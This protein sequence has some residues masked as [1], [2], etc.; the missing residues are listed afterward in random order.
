ME[1]SV[2]Y[3]YPYQ[4]QLDPPYPPPALASIPTVTMIASNTTI[5]TNSSASNILVLDAS[6]SVFS[7]LRITRSPPFS[8]SSSSSYVPASVLKQVVD[9]SLSSSILSMSYAWSDSNALTQM[10]SYTYS[11]IPY[12]MGTA[13]PTGTNITV[14]TPAYGLPTPVTNV[15]KS[16]VTNNGFTA[17]WSGG[18]GLSVTTVF[19]INGLSVTPSSLSEG[20]ATFTSL[21]GATWVLVI[22]PMNSS[23]NGVSGTVT[24]TLLVPAVLNYSFTSSNLGNGTDSWRGVTWNMVTVKNQVTGVYSAEIYTSGLTNNTTSSPAIVQ[25]FSAL[26]INTVTGSRGLVLGNVGGNKVYMT[27]SLATALSSATEGYDLGTSGAV[28][29]PGV[30]GLDKID[31]TVKST[32]F[33]MC[34]W[35]F[36]SL[37]SDGSIMYYNVDGGNARCEIF[38][39]NGN[40]YVTTYNAVNRVWG[41][42]L[43]SITGVEGSIGNPVISSAG[44]VHIAIT[45]TNNGS[46]NNGTLKMYYNGTLNST[47]NNVIYPGTSANGYI[48]LASSVGPF[49][50][51]GSPPG[52]CNGVFGIDQVRFYNSVV[53]DAYVQEIYNNNNY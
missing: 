11:I 23:G 46:Y 7:Y 40:I 39:N 27:S 10:T 18:Q 6:S 26:P 24:V 35:Y 47:T 37:R 50:W 3:R 31:T 25:L 1:I 42:R 13:A 32:G 8:S 12:V 49:M 4:K 16:A 29:G 20:T 48:S 53:T 17:S 19:T 52:Y 38:G 43:A 34:F 21:T 33:T 44:W 22:T 15:T 41:T 9:A 5:S 51:F 36:K 28:N 30:A 14:V 2:L 45:M